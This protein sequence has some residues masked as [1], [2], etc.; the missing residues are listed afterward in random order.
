[1]RAK[2]DE[3]LPVEAA[4]L[5]R[6]AGWECDTIYDEGLAAADDSKVAASCQADAR[7]LFT[8][9]LDFADIAPTRRA[10]PSASLYCDQQNPV[11]GKHSS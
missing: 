7:V 4:E 10:I 1:M 2:L 9:D 3:N 11:G 5:L 6:A 8:L